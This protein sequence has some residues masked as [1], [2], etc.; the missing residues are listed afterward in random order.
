MS[1]KIL[2]VQDEF[3][4]PEN[5]FS[6]PSTCYGYMVI[7]NEDYNIH[8]ILGTGGP[9]SSYNAAPL[10]SQYTNV[11]TVTHYVKTGATSWTITGT[12]T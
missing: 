11:A 6:Y 9:G 10:G 2:K 5:K 1:M 8:F 7:G 12:Q 3:A 4:D